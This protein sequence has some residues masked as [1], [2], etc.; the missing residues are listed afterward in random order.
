MF[1]LSVVALV[2]LVRL[3]VP[4]VPEAF[5]LQFNPYALISLA[6]LLIDLSLFILLM[7]RPDHS[8]STLWLAFFIGFG[9]LWSGSE[10]LERMAISPVGAMYWGNIV[11]GVTVYLPACFYI[12]VRHYTNRSRLPVPVWA[13]ASII[14]ISGAMA[15][16]LSGQDVFV[17]P[18][19]SER[20]P[21]GYV[22]S[23]IVE[24]AYIA[25]A[26]V[27]TVSAIVMLIGFFRRS[28]SEQDRRQSMLLIVSATAV[29]VISAFTEVL[30]P[31]LGFE[32]IP[33]LGVLTNALLALSTIIGIIKYGSFSVNPAD[34]AGTV[35]GNMADGVVVTDLE[36][37]VLY[38]NQRAVELVGSGGKDIMGQHVDALGLKHPGNNQYEWEQLFK[39]QSVAEIPGFEIKQ[40]DKVMTLDLTVTKLQTEQHGYVIMIVDVTD[41][42]R[43]NDSIAAQA[44]ELVASNKAFGNSQVAMLNLLEDA[45]ELETQLKREKAGVEQKIAERTIE[46]QAERE[47]LKAIINGVDFGIYMLGPDLHVNMVN[48]PMQELYSSGMEKPYSLASFDADAQD[49]VETQTDIKAAV[50]TRSSVSRSEYPRGNRIL[51]SF[52]SPMFEPGSKPP[53]LL[54]I[55]NVLQDITESKA[56]ERSRDEF[57][58][59][60]SHELR[61]PLTAIRGNTSMIQDY[62]ADQLKDPALKEMIGDIHDSS[63]RLITI[64]NDFLNTSR[65]EQGKIEFKIEPVD[66]A[67]LADEVLNEFKAGDAGSKVPI[68]LSLKPVPNVLADRDRLKEVLI[69]L[70]GNAVKFTDVGSVIV[71]LALDGKNVKLSVTDT[72]KGIPVGSQGLLFHKF[73][74]ASNNIL[75]RDSTRST[76]LGLYI[77]KLIMTGM[78]GEIFLEKSTA[79]KGAT[80]TILIPV[81]KSAIL[82]KP[83]RTKSALVG[84]KL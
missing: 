61:T 74:Q 11:S 84:A 40:G 15:A 49:N 39:D 30:L 62:F 22:S 50:K 18:T 64:V 76:G 45:R 79:G 28:K 32:L 38:S 47:S 3:L 42:K 65:L 4:I 14:G 41:K 51:R 1:A 13:I 77:S 37:L 81:V 9:A 23:S 55:I 63:I 35:L 75:T 44:K 19:V 8:D 83:I 10:A 68:K 25:W 34:I 57:F 54:G 69:N 17:M 82:A 58:S 72:G 80:F 36:Y 16:L 12:F 5:N 48:K 59:I 60:A 31:V 70:I 53:K 46:L 27:L 26:A 6:G 2:V 71:G 21:W 43:Y 24:V 33:P 73:Q 7:R 56:A 67:D 29:L 52:R 66:L 78:G 20:L